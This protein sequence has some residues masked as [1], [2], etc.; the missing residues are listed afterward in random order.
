MKKKIITIVYEIF[1]R[2]YE[3]IAILENELKKRGYE[4]RIKNKTMDFGI[5]KTDILVI[6]NCYNND[7][8]FFY[9]YRFNCKS[10]RIINLMIEQVYARGGEYESPEGYSK[11]IKTICWGEDRY[12]RFLNL[13]FS[14]DKLAITGPYHA[15][16]IG[17]PAFSSFWSSKEDIGRLYNLPMNK[18][19]ILFISDFVYVNDSSFEVNEVRKVFGSEFIIKRHSFEEKSQNA[20]LSWFKELLKDDDY[21]VIYRPHPVESGSKNIITFSEELKNKFYVISEKNIKQWLFVSDIITMWNSTSI[22]ECYYAKKGCLILRPFTSPEVEIYPLFDNC[23]SITDANMFVKAI[24]EYST[25]NFPIDLNLLNYYYFIG[26]NKSYINVCNEIEKEF[27]MINL[28]ESNYYVNRFKWF[29]N[30]HVILKTF[31]KKLYVLLFRISFGKFTLNK[32]SFL[33]IKEWERTIYYKKQY[34]RIKKL[35]K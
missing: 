22:I 16:Y 15:D 19:W 12:N 25:E 13:G 28:D 27:E 9:K 17:N 23:K 24:K 14:K 31:I 4:V 7:D 20:I 21:I 5:K 10:G 30:N 18:K 32:T 3:Y 1:R 26:D 11:L 34:K 8:Y 35:I 2:E 6:P 29:F 33:A